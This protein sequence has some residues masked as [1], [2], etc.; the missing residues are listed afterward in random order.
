MK[1]KSMLLA[2]VMGAA[3]AGGACADT[4]EFFDFSTPNDVF[5]RNVAAPGN[6]ASTAISI[7]YDPSLWSSVTSASL[8]LNL[9]DDADRQP[10]AA[11]LTDFSPDRVVTF[12]G[13][14]P[15]WYDAGDVTALLNVGGLDAF[16]TTLSASPGKD[17]FYHNAK[18]VVSFVPLPVP[19]ASG[20]LLMG[21]G[22]VAAGLVVRKRRGPLLA[23]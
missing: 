5:L 1:V 21:A 23:A 19:E 13:S 20:L 6:T 2:S 7:A 4:L 8:W 15:A 17:F 3:A 10:E 18:L 11:L 12:S 14:T 22:L 9:S 16:S